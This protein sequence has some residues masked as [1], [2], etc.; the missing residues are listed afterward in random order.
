MAQT[1][2][3]SRA[4]ILSRLARGQVV[5]DADGL[6]VGTVAD[7]LGETLVIGKNPLL[8]RE[9]YVPASA[10]ASVEPDRVTLNL[11]AADLDDQRYDASPETVDLDQGQIGAAPADLTDRQTLQLREEQLAVRKELELSGHVRVRKEVED[12]PRR[13]EADTYREEVT[14]EHV[15]IGRVVQERQPPRDEDGLYIMPIYEEQLVLVKQLILKEEIRIRRRGATERRLFEDTVRRERLVVED[16]ERTGRVRELYPTEQPAGE[17][18]TSDPAQAEDE[19]TREEP[20]LLER[21]G[22]K[23]LE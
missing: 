20:G 3:H 7:V 8:I 15:P 11:T 14:V 18:V 13:L 9:R 16:P 23:V 5:I 2:P 17:R 12:V 4:A 10:V 22:R 19:A 21:L 1:N 6:K